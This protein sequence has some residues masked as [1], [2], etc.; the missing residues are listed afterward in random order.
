MACVLLL[1]G[2]PCNPHPAKGSRDQGIVQACEKQQASL[3]VSNFSS[4]K[5]RWGTEQDTQYS[6]LSTTGELT[7]SHKRTH[8]VPLPCLQGLIFCLI[9]AFCWWSL[10]W[11]FLFDL[12]YFSCLASLPFSFSSRFLCLYWVSFLYF[13]LL[14]DFTYLLMFPWNS[15][16]HLCHLWIYSGF[17][18]CVYPCLLWVLC[19]YSN[20]SDLISVVSSGQLSWAASAMGLMHVLGGG[21]LA[22]F[23]TLR[24]T[25]LE[26]VVRSSWY[27]C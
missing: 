7:G 21:V 13:G 4:N 1:V 24:L 22:W 12:L 10:P 20:A 25:H 16:R 11:S 15:C 26:K 6:A 14:P 5:G 23:V 18:S 3:S 8:F 19:E 17:Y 27:T 2:L 9:L